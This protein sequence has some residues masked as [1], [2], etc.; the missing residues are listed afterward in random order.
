M[1]S[2]VSRS[3][4][5][6]PSRDV[7]PSLSRALDDVSLVRAIGELYAP[8]APEPD[9][10]AL[11]AALAGREI[12]LDVPGGRVRVDLGDWTSIV[13]IRLG[14]W[15]PHLLGLVRALVRPG[16]TVLDIGAHVGAWT[17]LFAS[18]VG[19][20]GSVIACEPSP[21]SAARLRA[22][23]DARVRVIETAIGDR[24]GR[25]TLFGDGDSMLRSLV[26][27]ALGGP[28]STSEVA[29]T[30]MDS[31]GV[32]RADLIKID[33]EGFELRVLRGGQTLLARC[34]PTLVIELHATALRALDEDTTDVFAWLRG[35]GFCVF[36]LRPEGTELCVEPLRDTPTTNHVLARRDPAG[37]VVPLR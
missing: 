16:A 21:A 25:A 36:D 19:P 7:P 14:A 30:T 33:T 11:C 2:R 23:T 6:V 20:T 27:E 22:M 26:P 13:M 35:E 15:E 34:D 17:M 3:R 18:L 31:L 12:T 10:V 1:T 29:I 8:G 5:E 32:E 37:F 24:V 28:S 4:D 9:L